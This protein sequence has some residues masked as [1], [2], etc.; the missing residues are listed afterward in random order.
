MNGD[1]PSR[2]VTHL[3]PLTV[4]VAPSGSGSNAEYVDIVGFSVMRI[5]SVSANSVSAYAITPVIP[6]LNDS[7]L[8]RGQEPRLVPWN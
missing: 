8:R 3:L 7:R 2:P 4:D 6:D 1:S 5:A